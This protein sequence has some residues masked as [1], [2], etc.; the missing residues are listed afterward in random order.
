[1]GDFNCKVGTIIPQNSE[2]ISTYGKKL[3]KLI[4]DQNLHLI[5]ESH[6][7][8]GVWTRIQNDQKA[9]L[10]YILM[11]NKNAERIIEANVD[12]EKEVTP[13]NLKDDICTDHCALSVKINWNV[14]LETEKPR[15][16]TTMELEKW[17]E[18][19][20]TLRF[21]TAYKSL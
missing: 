10:D 4:K 12:E 13:I 5:N 17:K 19:T 11:D 8:K 3:I 2:Q 20:R 14:K 21:R 18:L 7:T 6:K 1:M 9:V 16:I 15:K